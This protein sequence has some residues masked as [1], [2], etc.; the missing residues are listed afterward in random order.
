MTQ[1]SY[2]NWE[3]LGPRLGIMPDELLSQWQFCW[4]AGIAPEDRDAVVAAMV[5]S[6]APIGIGET[7]LAPGSVWWSV[8]GQAYR[9][10]A[11]EADTA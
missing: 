5:E 4:R 6:R 9:G 10:R 8:I 7:I 11:T 2:E 3:Q 1:R